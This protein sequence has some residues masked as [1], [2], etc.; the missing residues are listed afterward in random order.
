MA[1]VAFQPR[2]AEHRAVVSC[3]AATGVEGDDGAAG[4]SQLGQDAVLAAD[5]GI[6]PAEVAVDAHR[7]AEQVAGRVDEVDDGL[8]SRSRGMAGEIR[9]VGVRWSGHAVQ[10]AVAEAEVTRAAHGAG[11]HQALH[12][13]VPRLPAPV[14]RSPSG[15]CPRARN[16]PPW[17]RLRPW[18]APAASGTGQRIRFVLA[19]PTKRGACPGGWP[20]RR[21]RAP[22]SPT[23]H[24][25][26]LA[27]GDAEAVAQ[28]CRARPVGITERDNPAPP[29]RGSSRP[30][31]FSPKEPSA[32]QRASQH[33]YPSS[34]ERLIRIRIRREQA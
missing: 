15:G 26:W 2:R 21:S 32:D 13:P 23:A 27:P 19:A 25:R 17:R 14:S 12:L 31:D 4:D 10:G 9:L 29:P 34:A 30:T 18:R 1:P 16:L 7:I 28:R 6:H 22:R 11:V 8:E 33:G 20:R 24:R 3:R 5:G